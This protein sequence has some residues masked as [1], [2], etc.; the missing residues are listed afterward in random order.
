MS[1]WQVN[2]WYAVVKRGPEQRRIT[3][4]RPIALIGGHELCDVTIADRHSAAVA[5]IAVAYDRHIEVW[6]TCPLAFS[7]W[8]KIKRPE[9]EL[10]IGRSRVSLGWSAGP[11]AAEMDWKPAADLIVDWGDGEKRRKINR[12]VSILGEDHPS[13]IRLHG[14]SLKRCDQAVICFGQT[15]WMVDLC[16]ERWEAGEPQVRRLADSD[17]SVFLGG[18]HLWC[19]SKSSPDGTKRVKSVGD[20][21]SR[22][23]LSV[24]MDNTDPEVDQLTTRW[25]DQM[26]ETTARRGEKIKLVKQVGFSLVGVAALVIVALIVIKGIAPILQSIYGE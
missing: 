9:T 25:T 16:A 22:T 14:T 23:Q 3:L 10:L 19:A 2:D 13:V 15:I 8:G 11:G 5:Y 7:L 20:R 21:A 18:L 17:P 4:D 26:L 12:P 24:R 1:L 6:P